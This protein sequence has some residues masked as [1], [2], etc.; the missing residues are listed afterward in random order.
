[1]ITDVQGAGPKRDRKQ[2]WGRARD[3]EKRGG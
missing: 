3:D 2:I 1:M